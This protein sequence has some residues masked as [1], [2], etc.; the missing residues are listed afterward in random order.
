MALAIIVYGARAAPTIA[1]AT[2]YRVAL[3]RC[4]P[5]GKRSGLGVAL[6]AVAR[7]INSRQP[8][9]KR[10][11]VGELVLVI[12]TAQELADLPGVGLRGC[13]QLRAAGLGQDRISD[14]A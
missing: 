6:A 11:E 2:A 13:A 1:V 7:G 12:R 8:I 14:A 9:E 3:L 10:D 4:P 5:P